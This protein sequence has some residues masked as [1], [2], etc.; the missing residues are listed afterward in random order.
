MFAFDQHL[1]NIAIVDVADGA[2]DQ[3]AVVVDEGRGAGFQRQFP[4]V[5]PKPREIIEIALDLRLR[6]RQPSGAHNAAHRCW[7]VEV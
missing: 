5:I 3:V 2:F 1:F 6:P 4:N 7:Q